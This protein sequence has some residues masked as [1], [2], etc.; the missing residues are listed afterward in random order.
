[1]IYAVV[2]HKSEEGYTVSCPGLPGCISEG[3]T[4]QEA[5]ESIQDAIAG[6]ISVIK[7]QYSGWEKREVEV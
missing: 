3:E 7:E 5:L 6:Y 1:M 2:L 4:E